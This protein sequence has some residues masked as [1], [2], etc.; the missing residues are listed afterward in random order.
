MGSS[1]SRRA[2]VH[3][4]EGAHRRS[5]EISWG[6]C[7]GGRLSKWSSHHNRPAV[8][9]PPYQRA[10]GPPVW[11]DA[12]PGRCQPR[13]CGR[14]RAGGRQ[15]RKE[16]LAAGRP[17]TPARTGSPTSGGGEQRASF[18]RPTCQ[19]AGRRVL[20]TLRAGPRAVAVPSWVEPPGS[21][22]WELCPRINWSA[23]GFPNTTPATRP[24]FHARPAAHAQ[25]MYRG[26]RRDATTQN[27][28]GIMIVMIIMCAF[29]ARDRPGGRVFFPPPVTM[30]TLAEFPRLT[31]HPAVVTV[32][33]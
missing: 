31:G 22:R 30:P 14:A 2:M 9:L 17:P 20:V 3:W 23:A 16:S 29:P 1:P 18:G 21:T 7:G 5:G 24:T 8:G 6:F 26:Q 32:A 25:R 12:P 13:R 11:L 28:T 19:T 4:Q 10:I 27:R 15:S 33:A